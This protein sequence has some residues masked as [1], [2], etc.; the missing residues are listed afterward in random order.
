MDE[1]QD[2]LR[3]ARIMERQSAQ[4]APTPTQKKAHH[5]ERMSAQVQPSK[6]KAK[7][8]GAKVVPFVPRGNWQRYVDSY[9][10]DFVYARDGGRCFYCHC[11]VARFGAHFDHVLPA[12]RGGKASYANLVLSCAK[13]NI[14]KSASILHNI[15]A[16]LAEVKRRNMEVLG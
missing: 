13:C 7:G 9:L 3:I 1:W 11:D 8:Q 5:F 2:A 14:S 6:G 15:D 12:S 10:R 4:F 16:I